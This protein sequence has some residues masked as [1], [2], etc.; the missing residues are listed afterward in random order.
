MKK[1]FMLL[2]FT[3]IFA[4]LAGCG[5]PPPQDTPA[6]ATSG[7]SSSTE[8]A[9]TDDTP[10]K[11]ATDASY[12]P[13][14]F[15]DLD[16]VKGFDID[17]LDAVMKQAGMK[18]EVTNT[19]WDTM[20]ESVRQG[21]EYKA[22]ISSVSITADRKESYSFSLPYF[23]ST[24]VIMVKEG[25]DIKSALDLKNKKVAVQNGTTADILMSGIMGKDNSNLSRFESNALALLELDNGGADAVVADIAIV[26]EYIKNNPDKKLVSI[27][28]S[29]NF[30]SEYY[31]I[32][33]PKDSELK[34][35]LDPA[36]QAIIDNGTYA[37][38]YKKWFGTEPDL[39]NLKAEMAKG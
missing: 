8:T 7:E 4:M 35:K 18:Y 2:L 39:T 19:G 22:G 17:F 16:Q 20:L 13:M 5:A 30:N 31:G 28:D 9:A 10:I 26:N 12:A 24:N 6:A 29:K 32:L 1:P 36:I 14:E 34:A 23:E 3:L 21:T 15:M 38:I 37:E 27:S 25:S 33:Y 11:F